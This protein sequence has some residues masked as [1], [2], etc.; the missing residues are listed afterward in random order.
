[1]I[2]LRGASFHTKKALRVAVEVLYEKAMICGTV[3]RALRKKSR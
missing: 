1:M 3:K 2:R